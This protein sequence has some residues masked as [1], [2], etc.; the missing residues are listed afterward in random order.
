MVFQEEQ[1]DIF[2]G[3]AGELE[4]EPG[5]HAAGYPAGTTH[6]IHIPQVRSTSD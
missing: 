5:S 3:P 6:G 4:V 2:D 1:S